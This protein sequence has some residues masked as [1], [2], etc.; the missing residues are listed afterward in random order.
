M[1]NIKSGLH[2]QTSLNSEWN[3]NI[4]TNY[5]NTNVQLTEEHELNVWIKKML[6][7]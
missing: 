2:S 1:Q 7:Q 4:K 3:T 6:F 5:N